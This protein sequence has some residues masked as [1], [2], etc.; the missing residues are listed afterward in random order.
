MS[1]WSARMDQERM[2]TRLR[3]LD[4]RQVLL[5]KMGCVTH[6]QKLVVQRTAKNKC[7]PEE[8]LHNQL[9]QILQQF[10]DSYAAGTDPGVRAHLV[11]QVRM[12]LAEA[13]QEEG[14]MPNG[15]E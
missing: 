5:F 15:C 2:L 9:E 13:L 10:W 11:H 6:A 7:K 8:V 1:Y 3:Q 14:A 4:S 12:R